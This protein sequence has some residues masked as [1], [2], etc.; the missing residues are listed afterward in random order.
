MMFLISVNA[1]VVKTLHWIDAVGK[2][3]FEWLGLKFGA[4]LPMLKKTK[5]IKRKP[6]HCISTSAGCVQ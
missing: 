1:L 3:D 6:C 2:N 4:P 5:K